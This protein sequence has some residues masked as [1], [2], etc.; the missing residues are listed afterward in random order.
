MRHTL[1][2][3]DSQA[4]TAVCASCGPV[5]V[6]G[7]ARMRCGP[8]RRRQAQAHRDGSGKRTQWAGELRRRYGITIETWDAAL[9]AQSGRCATCVRP[10]RM[11]HTDHNHETGEFRGLLCPSCNRAIGLLRDDPVVALAVSQ[12]LDRG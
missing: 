12:Y 5:D 1:S 9:I 6:V 2:S 10:L 8:E 3:L 7:N 4:R 11:V